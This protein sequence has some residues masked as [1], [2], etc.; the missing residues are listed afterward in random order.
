MPSDA[1]AHAHLEGCQPLTCLV[2]VFK[3]AV[4]VAFT[5]VYMLG[6]VFMM[7][8]CGKCLVGK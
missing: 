5:T 2:I 4:L 8:L 7:A 1:G 6:V 3:I